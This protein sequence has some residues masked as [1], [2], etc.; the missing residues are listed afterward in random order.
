MWRFSKL[1]LFSFFFCKDGSDG[2]MKR[3]SYSCCNFL[4]I[5]LAAVYLKYRLCRLSCLPFIWHLFFIVTHT[6]FFLEVF[7]IL[8]GPVVSPAGVS[9]GLQLIGSLQLTI[10]MRYFNP[11]N[12][13]I[14]QQHI[15]WATT[16]R[17]GLPQPLSTQ[18]QNLKL[19]QLSAALVTYPVS[20]YCP[21]FVF[22][23]R[24]N[25]MP[26]FSRSLAGK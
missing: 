2:L 18:M 8:G 23:H 3:A 20:V 22:S 15:V 10:K 7:Y 25:A 14:H 24:G 6:H 4:C 9:P 13:H 21:R 26:I 16:F 5:V 12:P 11:A 19:L 17:S 1:L